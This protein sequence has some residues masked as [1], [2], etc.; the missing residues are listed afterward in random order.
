MACMDM[1]ELQEQGHMT[2]GHGLF[3]KEFLCFSTMP[4]RPMPLLVRF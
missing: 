4:C 2:T 1:S 3:R